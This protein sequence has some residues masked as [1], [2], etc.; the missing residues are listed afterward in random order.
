M[1]SSDKYK[2]KTLSAKAEIIKKLE[3]GE[4]LVNLAKEYGVGCAAIYNIRKNR[5]KIECFVK[6]PTAAPV[7]GRL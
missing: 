5:E 7:T 1:S 4:K 6:I 3:K 2:H